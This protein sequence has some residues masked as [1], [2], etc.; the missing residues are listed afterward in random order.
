MEKVGPGNSLCAWTCSAFMTSTSQVSDSIC[1]INRY[2]EPCLDVLEDVL[3]P[4]A[5]FALFQSFG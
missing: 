1:S 2:D 5:V 4:G 3:P